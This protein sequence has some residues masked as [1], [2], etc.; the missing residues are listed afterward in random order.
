MI[1]IGAGAILPLLGLA[2]IQAIAQ[3]DPSGLLRTTLLRLPMALLLTGVVIELVSLGLTF[4]DQAS[5]ALLN[6]GGNAVGRVF[7]HLEE[8]VLPTGPVGQGLFGFGELV[9]VVLVAVVGFVLWLE[10]AVRS[11]AVAVAALFL[12][13]ALSGLVWP[14]TSH[15][16]RRLGETL[17]GLVLMKLVMAAVLALAGGALAADAGGVSSVVEG[18]ALL[19]LTV[20]SPFVLFR[21]IPMIEAGAV[22]HLEAARPAA[23]VSA[24]QQKVMGA[25]SGLSNASKAAASR[26]APS[27]TAI[28]PLPGPG[29]NLTGSSRGGPSS[30]GV[31]GGGGP[32]NGGG[33]G[34]GASAGG[35]GATGVRGGATGGAG[36]SGSAAGTRAPASGSAA[37]A[38]APAAAQNGAAGHKGVDGWSQHMAERQRGSNAGS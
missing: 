8:A 18:V 13:L 35:G 21:L 29:V 23:S 24:G 5:L 36:P 37:G 11:A 34:G 38:R 17:A 25:V 22:S 6:T 10:L 31:P 15:W 19:G 30:G 33:T 9:L 20:T 14:A 32:S 16:A 7:A 4:T 28:P 27:P 26:S 3:Q 1:L 12:P 2:V